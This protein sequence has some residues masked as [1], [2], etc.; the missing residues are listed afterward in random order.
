MSTIHK[1]STDVQPPQDP[2]P[3]P[4]GEDQIPA[5]LSEKERYEKKKTIKR[6]LERLREEG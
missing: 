3:V 6:E 1:G 4:D 2:V 5:Q